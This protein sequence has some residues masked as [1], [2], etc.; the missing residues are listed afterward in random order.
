MTS[1]RATV[2][3]S[4]GRFLDR[5]ADGIPKP[6]PLPHNLLAYAGL[7]TVV[8][9]WA[10]MFGG[11]WARWG[12]VT[13]DCG[14][15]MYVP[16]QMLQG[17]TL[18]RDLWYPYGPLAPYLNSILFRVAG[19][20]LAVLYWAGSLSALACAVTLYFIGLQLS[21]PVAGWTAATFLLAEAFQPTY[22]SF[23]LPY[24]F[25]SVYGAVA[26]CLCY[27]CCVN[28]A[29][30]AS[31]LSLFGAGLAAC[32]ALLSKAEMGVGCWAAVVVLIG[33]RGI[34]N[35]SFRQVARSFLP[36]LPGVVISLAVIGWM[37]SL[38]GADFLIQQNLAGF[39]TSYFAK[40]F[41]PRW[42]AVT[43]MA[44]DHEALQR[45]AYSGTA[46]LWLIIL[47]WVIRRFGAGWGVLLAM[48]FA[49]V[50]YRLIVVRIGV[51]LAVARA[52][53]LP[54]AM[55]LLIVLAIPP[56]LMAV[57]LRQRGGNG[58]IALLALLIGSSIAAVR[59]LTKTVD[60]GYSI[61]FNGPVILC[62]FLLFTWLAFPTR[63]GL[64]IL[65]RPAE[66][67]PCLALLA[68]IALPLV[69]DTVLRRQ[70]MEPWRT[71]RGLI[72]LPPGMPERY[73][74]AVEF[75]QSAARRGDYTLSVSE[76]VSLYFFSGTPA[77]LRFYAFTPG[78]VAP[79][80]MMDQV[81]AQIERAKVRYLIWS[82]RT[83]IEYGTPEFG[84]DFD[85]PLGDY[86]RSRFVPIGSL[87][88]H[89]EWAA[90]IW[91]R[92]SNRQLQ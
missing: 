16:W 14:R 19:V 66:A 31:W 43:G 44:F 70:L 73:Q 21:S 11:T 87:P 1:V 49:V 13:I 72:F 38:G 51:P 59:T 62:F 2:G 71:S 37:V 29:R 27:W 18:Y 50:A 35:S 63:P 25:A 53:F 48:S 69:R 54:P 55:I 47:G 90:T 34:W 7:F 36:T 40:E 64:N 24:S 84:K 88:G 65:M 56:L 22:F 4:Q 81:I 85:Q 74:A 5:L 61:Y 15:E 92:K 26:A 86:L 33:L 79:G 28:A 57:L 17:K 42:N 3:N 6:R 12:S 78:V 76:D 41:G 83:Y 68:V 39:P 82:N 23:P 32:A 52:A 75:I 91:E 80:Q 67:L 9:F 89:G 45:I 20:N 10:V 60:D 30:S 58:V 46:I 8:C 77:P